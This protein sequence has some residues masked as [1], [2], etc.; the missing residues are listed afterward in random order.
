MQTDDPLG[1]VTGIDAASEVSAELIPDPSA[2][3]QI[4]PPV[5]AEYEAAVRRARSIKLQEYEDAIKRD[6]AS[7]SQLAKAI[8]FSQNSFIDNP[9]VCEVYQKY[10]EP[11]EKAFAAAHGAIID[12][13]YCENVPAAT[14]L[15]AKHELW[16]VDPPLEPDRVA[17]A[18]LLL[19]C[20]RLNGETDRVLKGSGERLK[21]RERTKIL[22]YWAVVKLLSL[23]DDPKQSAP[24]RVVE[25]YQREVEHARNYYQRAASRHAQIDYGLGMLIG[26][27]ICL[28]AAFGAW[29]VIHFTPGLARE[30]ITFIGCLLAGGIGAVVSVMSRMTFGGLSL[31]YEAGRRILTMLGAFRPI[32]GMVL[33][34]AMWVLTGSGVLAV[35]PNDPTKIEFFRV[36]AA[37][38]AGFSERWA[39][40]MLGRAA[41][42]LEGRGI[43]SWSVGDGAHS[44]SRPSKTKGGRS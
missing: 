43:D 3:A 31:D 2:P 26:I 8:F 23:A 7:F 40:D 34:A 4:Q 29:V 36:L 32:I 15:T 35:V 30:G 10:K 17:I 22:L 44:P 38:L 28:T 5:V 25:L 19:E 18:E 39:Q 1:Q 6:S 42:H 20:E 11:V 9:V 14:V 13:F 33:G 16:I 21:D 37:F 24:C 41:S 27:A 12:S